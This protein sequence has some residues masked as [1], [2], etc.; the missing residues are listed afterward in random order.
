M[1]ARWSIIKGVACAAVAFGP[2][3]FPAASAQ[4]RDTVFIDRPQQRDTVFID[5]P[6]QRDTL[7][8]VRHDTVWTTP[9]PGAVAESAAEESRYDRRAHRYRRRWEVLIPTHTKLQ[10][11]GNMGLL[12]VG[13]GWDYGRRNRWETD[14]FL[15]VLPK[16]DSKRTKLTFTV[17]Q[18]FMPWNVPVGRSRFSVEPLACGL[19]LNT[20][21]GDEFWVHEPERY[22]KGYYGFSSKVRI[23][24]FLGQRVTYDID[25]RRRFTAKAVTFFYEVS[26]SDLYIVSAFTNRYL[27]PKDF[28][29]LSFGV[30]LQLL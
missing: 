13:T 24:L 7:F 5:N 4:Q 3:C 2:L 29:C 30:K 28:L 22:P 11:A 10:Y 18:N 8:I 6:Q 16:Y 1:S 9:A 20:V 26:T 27:R 19:Y 17:K 15:G 25:P 23:N 12:S 14:I 21:F